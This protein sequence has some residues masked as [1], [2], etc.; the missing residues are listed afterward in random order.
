MHCAD[1]RFDGPDSNDEQCE[2]VASCHSIANERTEPKSFGSAGQTSHLRKVCRQSDHQCF[3]GASFDCGNQI[4]CN[5]GNY[6]PTINHA[7][8][9]PLK[10]C[11][12]NSFK[13]IRNDFICK[14]K[15]IIQN[16]HQN[17][18]LEQRQEATDR[19]VFDCRLHS[20]WRPTNVHQL[21]IGGDDDSIS[22]ID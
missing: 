1:G 13:L 16:E 15:F 18:G 7:R 12:R 9:F 22:A 3:S 11:N 21:T 14:I 20:K 2:H 8:L 10:I 5:S 6:G 17:A 4:R 19:Q